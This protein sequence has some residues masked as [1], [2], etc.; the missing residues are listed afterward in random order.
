MTGLREGD[1]A[2]NL[3]VTKDEITPVTNVMYG[4]SYSG[5]GD[6]FSSTLCGG[7]VKGLD[8]ISATRLAGDFISKAVADTYA[9]QTDRND[10]V[11]FQKYLG[12]LI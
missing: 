7:V 12:M 8:V 11:N 5:T 2:T 10:G 1:H 4:G 6:L 3:V 9:E